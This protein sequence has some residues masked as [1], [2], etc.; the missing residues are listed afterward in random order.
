MW[1]GQGSFECA[2]F[3]AGAVGMR[4]RI[5]ILGGDY[6]PD[7]I[8][9]E[10]QVWKRFQLTQTHRRCR[11]FS[12][13][14]VHDKSGVNR[15]RCTTVGG[16][17]GRRWRQCPERLPSST[18]SSSASIGTETHGETRRDTAK[19]LTLTHFWFKSTIS[20]ICFL[21]WRKMSSIRF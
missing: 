11:N 9:D 19:A 3:N 5:Y 20:G 7:E 21:P 15:C 6:C 12:R 16:V 2:G 14:L 4:D 13:A 1:K 8:T 10:V 18:A 17:S